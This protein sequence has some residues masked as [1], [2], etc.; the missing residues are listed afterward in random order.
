MNTG[1]TVHAWVGKDLK[2]INLK[3]QYPDLFEKILELANHE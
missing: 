1:S 2:P 3:K